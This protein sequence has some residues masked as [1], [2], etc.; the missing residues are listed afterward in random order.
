MDAEY[1]EHARESFWKAA[2]GALQILAATRPQDR[3]VLDLA[4]WVR[5]AL[6][7][8]QEAITLGQED[9]SCQLSEYADLLEIRNA[10]RQIGGLC[11]KHLESPS[12]Q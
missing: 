8:V 1:W 12:W 6:E 9:D 5:S 4:V 10:L 3:E 7:E 2:E 11:E